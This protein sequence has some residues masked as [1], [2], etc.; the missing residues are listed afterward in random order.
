MLPSMIFGY[1]IRWMIEE[2]AIAKKISSNKQQIKT[3][4]VLPPIN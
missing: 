3:N 1:C 4:K 2:D